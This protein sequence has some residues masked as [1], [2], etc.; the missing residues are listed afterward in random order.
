MIQDLW[1][2]R[3]YI[4][5]NGI[6]GLLGRYQGTALGWVWA[7]LPSLALI[8]IYA[9][10]F[11]KIMPVHRVG[12]GPVTVSFVLY[13]AS[14]LLPWMAFSEFLVR[15]SQA[16]LEATPYLK[17]MPI[18]EVVFVAQTSVGVLAIL[19]IYLFIM[20]LTA[21]FFGHYPNPAWLLMFPI[22]VLLG[23]LGFGIGCILA[24]LNVF[25]R[26]VGQALGIILQIWMWMVPVIYVETVVPDSFKYLFWLNPVYPFLVGFRE[27]FLYNQLPSILV[28]GAMVGWAAL[29]IQLGMGL[30]HLLRGEIRDAI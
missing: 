27:V 16:L 7:F 3:K 18:K 19:G 5:S 24:A 30:L 10:V 15:G 1:V 4:L 28:W 21:L 17:K 14:G 22:A 23:G 2:H 25:F 8:A 9:V 11:S 29:F 20:C 26:D 12:T 6:S 13:L